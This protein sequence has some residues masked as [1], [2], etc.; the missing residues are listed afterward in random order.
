MDSAFEDVRIGA[1]SPWMVSVLVGAV[2]ASNGRTDQA[3][4]PRMMREW[5]FREEEEEERRSV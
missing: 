5:E 2:A 4:S 1:A 3:I